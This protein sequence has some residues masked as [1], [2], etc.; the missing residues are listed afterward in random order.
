MDNTISTA[1]SYVVYNSLIDSVEYSI[2]GSMHYSV[3]AAARRPVWNT[4]NWS[5]GI[6]IE[7]SASD[8]FK[9]NE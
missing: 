8:Y 3:R 2:N 4:V 9:Q 7:Q 6:S 5:V 1:V